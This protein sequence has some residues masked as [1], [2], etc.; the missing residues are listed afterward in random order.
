MY[1]CLYF[2]PYTLHGIQIET[3]IHTRTQD[4]FPINAS[5]RTNNTNVVLWLSRFVGDHWN[6]HGKIK[7]KKKYNHSTQK[8][9]LHVFDKNAEKLKTHTRLH[10]FLRFA[11]R[12]RNG[13]FPQF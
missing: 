4:S 7:M 1:C 6:F 13:V 10:G 5:F 11:V 2:I 9:L 8:C 12:T 3:H